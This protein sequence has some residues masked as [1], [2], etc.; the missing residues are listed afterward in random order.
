MPVYLF[1][2]RLVVAYRAEI[3]AWSVQRRP[4]RVERQQLELPIAG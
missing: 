3:D 4:T 2:P 1:G